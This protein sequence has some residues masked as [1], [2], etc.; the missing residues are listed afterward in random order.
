MSEEDFKDPS[1]RQYYGNNYNKPLR[2]FKNTKN[3]LND[4]LCKNIQTHI[5][6]GSVLTSSYRKPAT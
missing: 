5:W 2:N 6:T 4:N 3:V 1:Y